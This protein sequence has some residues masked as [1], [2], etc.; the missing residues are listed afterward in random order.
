MNL[1]TSKNQK[2]V[3]ILRCGLKIFSTCHIYAP[4]SFFACALASLDFW[5]FRGTQ[6]YLLRVGVVNADILGSNN[7]QYKL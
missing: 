3:A 5:V 2:L 7:R 4:H 1:R 6:L